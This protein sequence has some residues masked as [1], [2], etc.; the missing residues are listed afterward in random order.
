VPVGGARRRGTWLA[1]ATLALL[2][3]LVPTR[4][5]AQLAGQEALRLDASGTYLRPNL[6]RADGSGGYLHVTPGDMPWRV[7]IG[8]PPVPARFGSREDARRA[9]IEAMQMWEEALRP[10]APWFRLEFVESDPAA[11]VQVRW[12]RRITGPYGGFGRQLH[13]FDEGGLRVG[14]LIEISTTPDLYTTL[15]VDEVRF[16]VAHEFGHVLGLGHC[17]ECDSAMNY[18][19]HTR[20]RVLVTPADVRTFQALLAQPNPAQP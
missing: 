20:E 12:K 14:G 19:W 2:L 10:V 8:T 16:L 7:A 3:A 1:G 11:P 18:A 6:Q 13:R 17:L 9:A 4:A 5:P 15:T